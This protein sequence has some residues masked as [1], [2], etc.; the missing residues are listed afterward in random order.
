VAGWSAIAMRTLAAPDP[1]SNF[2]VVVRSVG[3]INGDGYGD[4]AVGADEYM[5][6]LG[7]VYVYAG[8]PTGLGTTPWAVLTGRSGPGARFGH[9][10]VGSADVNGDGYGDLAVAVPGARSVMLYAGHPTALSSEPAGYVSEPTAGTEFGAAMSLRADI[11]QYGGVDLVV[12]DPSFASNAGWV[13]GFVLDGTFP[14]AGATTMMATGAVG[15][16]LGASVEGDVDSTLDGI[17]DVTA[18][19]PGALS[20][21]GEVRRYALWAW[22]TPAAIASGAAA[23]NA[24]GTTLSIVGDVNGDGLP[25]LVAGSPTAGSSAGAI[26]LVLVGATP[27]LVTLAG[28]GMDRLGSALARGGDNDGDGFADVLVGADGAGGGAGRVTAYTGGLTGLTASSTFM[29]S[30]TAGSMEHVGRVLALRART[31]RLEVGL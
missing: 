12:G 18:G 7:R 31:T 22:G 6:G 4:L 28:A 13:G 20:G 8:G 14:L 17:A 30:G 23:G 21:A 19:A 24:V 11:D 9:N 25:D 3:D 27:T 10:V 5:S 1:M 15:E 16:R 29:V 2:G 26:T